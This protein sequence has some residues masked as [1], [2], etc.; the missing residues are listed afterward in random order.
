MQFVAK[1]MEADLSDVQKGTRAK[2]YW[3]AISFAALPELV[4]RCWAVLMALASTIAVALVAV[5]SFVCYGAAKLLAKVRPL[6]DAYQFLSGTYDRLL[7][8]LGQKVLRDPRDTPALRLMVSLS[9]TPLPIFVVQLALGKPRLLLAIAFYLS[10]YG[11]KFE[12][13]IR[14]FS[15]KHLE[16]HRRQ[17][18]FSEKYDRVF[19][20]YVEFFLGYLYGNVPELDRT[21]HVGLH[22]RENGGPDDTVT[23]SRYDRTSSLDFLWYLSDNIWTAIGLAP[24]AYF[25]AK[26][27]EKNR[28]RILWGMAR[29]YFFFAAVFIYNWRIGILYVLVPLL[30]MNFIMALTAW[31]QHAFCDPEHPEDYFANTVTV[32]DELNF[33][34][35]GY[36]LCH[37]H[38]SSLHWT[39]MPAHLERIRDKM[40]ES[41]SLVFRD[42][43]VMGL[44]FE[45]TVLRRMDV[46]A[47]KLVP[48]QPMNHEERLALL[49]KRTKP[50]RPVAA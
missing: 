42:L 3:P 26:G 35:E 50:A 10:L 18:Y 45:L 22:H 41:G 33:M 31:V 27:D 24:Y 4:L 16:A 48:W 47:E 11:L 28:R 9:L 44:F 34:N 32:L 15:A 43:D 5:P 2:A 17:G 12:R 23:S 8:R 38:R 6:R 46:L 40:R 13:F 1:L 25:K 19:G 49:E 7:E 36:H 37:H 20:R 14:M 21:V 30:T 39:E 29:Y